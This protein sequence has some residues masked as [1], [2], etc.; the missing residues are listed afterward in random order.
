MSEKTIVLRLKEIE[1]IIDRAAEKAAKNALINVGLADENA[2]HDIRD[3]RS[4]LTAINSAKRTAW[5]TFIRTLTMGI[6]MA[7]MAGIAIKFK[8]FG[9][10]A[11]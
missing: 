1:L 3:L 7:L 5:Q 4:L 8:V 2:A 10:G 6:I 9:G 11:S